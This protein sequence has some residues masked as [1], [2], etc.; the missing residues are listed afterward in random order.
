LVESADVIV[1]NYRAGKLDELGLGY[2]EVRKRRPDII[3]ASLNA[4]G[5]GGPWTERAGYEHNAQAVTGIQVRQ[6]GRNSKPLLLTYPMNDYSTGLLGAY[7]VMLALWERR[8]TGKGQRVHASLAQSA[9]LLSSRYLFDYAGYER[10]ELEGPRLLGETA[11]SRLYAAAD[12]WLYLHANGERS[13]RELT[14][15]HGFST[16]ATDP[17]FADE[18]LRTSNDSA[19]AAE[20]TAIIAGRAR[21]LLMQDL[22]RA[23]IDAAE[24]LTFAEIEQDP[25]IETAGLVVRTEFPGLGVIDH[26]GCNTVELSVTPRRVGRLNP[27][28]G[29]DGE[30]IRAELGYVTR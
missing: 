8:V 28:L 6:G 29:L 19:L 30:E 7:A 3:Y 25:S 21:S 11:V 27:T 14:G 4:F 5:H 2:Q 20:L 26:V 22:K 1:E 10:S 18:N 16:L 24:R 23:G 17:R 13:W 12:G 9:S 15:L